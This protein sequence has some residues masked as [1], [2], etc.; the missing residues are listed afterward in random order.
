MSL[1]KV[2]IYL[3]GEREN[4]RI[5]LFAPKGVAVINI[6]GQTIHLDLGINVGGKL[7]R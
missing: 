5:L 7:Y 2:L 1:S 4:P 6:N 3:G